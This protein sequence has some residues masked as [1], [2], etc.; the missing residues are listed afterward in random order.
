MWFPFLHRQHLLFCHVEVRVIVQLQTVAMNEGM[1]S[2]DE[3]LTI[4]DQIRQRVRN[5]SR[6]SMSC[7]RSTWISILSGVNRQHFNLTLNHFVG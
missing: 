6:P 1:C 7:A 3:I 4:E 5:K 2:I